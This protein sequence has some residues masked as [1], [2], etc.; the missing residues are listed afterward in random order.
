MSIHQIFSEELNRTSFI[1][2]LK[3]YTY[4][5]IVYNEN[6]LRRVA[7]FYQT[8]ERKF[9]IKILYSIK[10]NR[11]LRIVQEYSS[12][13][14]GVD[15]ASSTE[16]DIA[17]KSHPRTISIT[18][19]GFEETEV[20]RLDTQHILFDCCTQDQVDWFLNYH[21]LDDLGVRIKG[22]YKIGISI[23]ELSLRPLV[24]QRI[25][26]VHFHGDSLIEM[27][28][29]LANLKELLS[30]EKIKVINLGGGDIARKI[31]TQN[32]VDTKLFLNKVTQWYPKADLFVEPGQLLVAPVG[33]LETQAIGQADGQLILN[34]S[35]FNLSSWYKPILIWPIVAKGTGSI[36]GNT[37]ISGDIFAEGVD[38]SKYVSGSKFIFGMAGAYFSSTHREL[39]GNKFPAENFWSM[40]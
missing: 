31:L 30:G 5:T 15:C 18:G 4:P 27:T 36:V 38:I 25:R 28:R 10:A 37:N 14:D 20:H 1:T 11:N 21:F 16:L 3:E 13:L 33:F 34:T 26:R 7:N 39:H 17:L 8:E 24:C 9:A 2:K 23:H 40:S 6:I 19:R 29:A 35:P 32:S 12:I 22:Q